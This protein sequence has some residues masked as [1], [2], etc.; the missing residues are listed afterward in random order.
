MLFSH[1]TEHSLA[2]VVDRN[3]QGV[4]LAYG[5]D[6]KVATV[7]DSANRTFAFTRDGSGRLTQI[8]APGGLSVGYGYTNGLLTSYTDARGKVWTYTYESRA[9]LEKEIDLSGP[10]GLV[11]SVCGGGVV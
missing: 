2:S 11:H 7:T 3:G 9:L 8:A 10:R 6:G 5:G 4:T 1:D